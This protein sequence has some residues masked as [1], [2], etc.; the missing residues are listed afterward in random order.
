MK[1]ALYLDDIRTPIET[2]E[3]YHP[4]SIVRN[5]EEFVKHIEV[6]GIPDLISFD[7]D[8]ADEHMADYW[9]KQARGVKNISYEKFK[10]KTG[11]DCLNWLIEHV[12]DRKEVSPFIVWVHSHNPMGAAN[13]LVKAANFMKHMDWKLQ[14]FYAQPKFIIE[15]K[16]ED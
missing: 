10:E 11:V 14:V 12:L 4:W 7:H 8:L 9:D 15:T 16:I 6:N 2:L 5:Y 1:K 3:G 13:I